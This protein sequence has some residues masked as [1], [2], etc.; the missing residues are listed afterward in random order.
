LDILKPTTAFLG[1]MYVGTNRLRR[2][3]TAP[4]RKDL[5]SLLRKHDFVGASLVSLNFAF[6]LTRSRPAAQDLRDR[7]HVRLVEQGWDPG[8]VTLV[9]CL[10]RFVWSEHKN[11]T[12]ERV[13]ARKAEEVFL[14]EQRIA[15]NGAAPS[16]EDLAV[17]LETE[18][19]ED[20]HAAERTAS[21]RAAFVQAGDTVNQL[22]LDHWLAGV[23]EPGEMARLSGRDVSD[24]YRAADR[25][26]RHVARL[27]ADKSGAKIEEN[28]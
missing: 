10:C 11:E 19:Q 24:F 12:R 21:L 15:D 8:V 14:R 4:E 22:W 2:P 20:E 9:K 3:L 26:K 18:R 25:R 17:R 28:E 6:K 13:L 7:A 16:V 27:L 23:E 1:T 5:A